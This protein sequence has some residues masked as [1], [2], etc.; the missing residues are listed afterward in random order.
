M[1][2][3]SVALGTHRRFTLHRLTRLGFAIAL[4]VATLGSHR[5]TGNE[6]GPATFTSGPGK[7]QLL[8]LYTSEGCSSC[9]P[10]ERWLS[11]WTQHPDLWLGVV[12]VVFHVDYWNYL[13]WEDPFS[14]SA[15]SDRQR[16]H[17]EEGGVRSVYT[18]GFVV[19]GREWRGWFRGSSLPNRSR[20]AGTLEVSVQNNRVS[21]RY[22]ALDGEPAKLS[23]EIALLG[24]D[25]TTPVRA[26]E[27]RGRALTH[28]FSVLAHDRAEAVSQG[29]GNA[30]SLE[31]PQ[32]RVSS[33]RAALAV[34]VT[35]AGRLEPLQATG[36]WLPPT[37]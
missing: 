23:L 21:A 37:D 18:P 34:W 11:S 14:S 1:Y 32:P 31:I 28:Q 16:R 22:D 25:L 17:A 15:W 26:G 3:S 2:V 36:G 33:E 19:D 27:N 13:G 6:Y 20:A 5:A 12:P 10:A 9:P 7:V 24:F 8:E 29:A 4:C 30:W 35:A